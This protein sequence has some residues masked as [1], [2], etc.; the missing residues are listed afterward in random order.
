MA[1]PVALPDIKTHLRLSQ[2]ATD[3]DG[4]LESLIVAA[5]RMVEKETRHK[6]TGDVVT[7]DDDDLEAARYANR[8]SVSADSRP[9]EVPQSAAWILEGLRAWDD[10][11]D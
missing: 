10:G 11:S 1:E 4:Y 2:S 5:R 9:V 7:M 3:E 8:E 6:I